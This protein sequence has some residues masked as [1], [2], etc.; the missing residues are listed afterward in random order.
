MWQSLQPAMVHEIFAALDLL[1]RR[2]RRMAAN[3]RRAR[4]QCAGEFYRSL[5]PGCGSCRPVARLSDEA[6]PDNAR[7]ARGSNSSLCASASK[8]SMRPWPTR[9]AQATRRSG[10][11]RHLLRKLD[12]DGRGASLP[13]LPRQSHLTIDV[14]RI[15]A[16]RRRM[17]GP[18]DAFVRRPRRRGR[19]G[20]VLI[21]PAVA[22]HRKARVV[23]PAQP[24]RP[25]PRQRLLVE[26][27]FRFA[28]AGAAAG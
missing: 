12:K 23:A 24:D 10:A 8:L 26:H 20:A 19:P 1:G 14:R 16:V 9:I 27:E 15:G 11:T 22:R 18:H 17:T 5:L 13:P 28:P 7:F 6:Q 3:M 2:R 21:R 4:K 25:R